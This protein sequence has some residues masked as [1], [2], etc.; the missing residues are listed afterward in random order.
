MPLASLLGLSSSL[1]SASWPTS[2]KSTL[3]MWLTKVQ[4]R[5]HPAVPG[6]VP[7][8]PHKLLICSVRNLDGWRWEAQWDA[9]VSCLDRV[10]KTG[11]IGKLDKEL[12]QL[13]LACSLFLFC[14][15]FPH[16]VF[17]AL[18]NLLQPEWVGVVPVISVRH[19]QGS[20]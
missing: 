13:F 10:S 2:A 18:L 3:R 11:S 5:C 14:F 19:D 15:V 17:L 4:G 8:L 20:H 6:K 7:G 9:H 16:L 1:S 12:D